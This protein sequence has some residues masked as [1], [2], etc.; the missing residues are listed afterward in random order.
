MPKPSIGQ[1]V[2]VLAE[3]S[4]ASNPHPDRAAVLSEYL[5]ESESEQAPEKASESEQAPE[6]APEPVKKGK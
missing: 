5:A 1:V 3:E 4:L 6:K 2:R